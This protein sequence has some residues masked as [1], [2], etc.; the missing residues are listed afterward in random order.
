M[1][2]YVLE[3]CRKE[4]AHIVQF[5]L[6]YTHAQSPQ[7]L[8]VCSFESNTHVACILQLNIFVKVYMYMLL[9]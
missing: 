6:S 2:R 3:I 5:L 7:N 4:D 9:V 1:N 8:Y